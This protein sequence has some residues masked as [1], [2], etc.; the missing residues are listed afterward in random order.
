MPP[1]R[2]RSALAAAGTIVT[3]STLATI[4]DAE[5]LD[6]AARPINEFEKALGGRSELIAS[7]AIDAT[8]EIKDLVAM[9]L[10]PIYD[11]RSLGWLA[12]SVNISLTDLLRAYRN[13]MLAK[14][15]ILAAQH[16]ANRLPEIVDDVMKRAMPYE[17]TCTGCDGTGEMQTRITAKKPESTT[18]TCTVCGGRKTLRRIPDLDRQRLALELGELIKTP[19]GGPTLLQ[20][21]NLNPAGSAGSSE[22][23]SLERMQQAV[24]NILF[25]RDSIIDVTPLDTDTT[26]HG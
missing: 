14:A 17:E 7:L 23:G 22:P 20:Q 11:K 25:S 2:H 19:R 24:S 13:S 1:R 21:F 8:P 6:Y 18:I 15:Q 12:S 9:L 26:P 5:V 4:P 10:D 16:I 3:P